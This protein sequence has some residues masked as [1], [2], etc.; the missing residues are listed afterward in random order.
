M[1]EDLYIGARGIRW[2]FPL[3]LSAVP[4][5]WVAVPQVPPEAAE[6]L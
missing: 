2:A 3:W 1:I 5:T 4:G 6:V